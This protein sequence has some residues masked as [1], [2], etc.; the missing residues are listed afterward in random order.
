[1][2]QVPRTTDRET[3]ALLAALAD[4]RESLADDQRA[5]AEALLAGSVETRDEVAM[6]RAL[7]NDLRALP[8][9]APSPDWRTLEASI[10]RACADVSTVPRWWNWPRL[11]WP[12]LG[13]TATVLAGLT[14]AI[15][16]RTPMLAD[17][18]ALLP[19]TIEDDARTTPEIPVQLPRREAR[20]PDIALV[21]D[22]E[23]IRE[24]EIDESG[25]R[26][27]VDQLPVAAAITLGAVEEDDDE[28]LDELLPQTTFDEEINKMDGEAIHSLDR[29]LDAPEQKG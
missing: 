9:R 7:V 11:R 3:A 13:L 15:W 18:T 5:R 26:D 21:L 20:E 25:V 19:R 8:H 16:S 12:V 1:M 10:Q 28:V 4:G 23:L 27:L 24:D 29:W 2:S 14:L 17:Q 6:H 22:D